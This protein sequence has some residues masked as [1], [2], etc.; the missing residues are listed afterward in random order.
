[1]QTVSLLEFFAL[2]VFSLLSLDMILLSSCVQVLPSNSS[3]PKEGLPPPIE[4]RIEKTK[5]PFRVLLHWINPVLPDHLINCTGCVYHK[6]KIEKGNKTIHWKYR[7]INAHNTYQ[8]LAVKPL[9]SLRLYMCT[10]QTEME[11]SRWSEP[12][13]RIST[14]SESTAVTNLS[15]VCL[16]LEKMTC[17]WQPGPK[18]PRNTTYRLYYW[19]KPSNGAGGG[20]TEYSTQDKTHQTC[21]FPCNT[22]ARYL[23][24]IN[25]S[26]STMKINPKSLIIEIENYVKPAVPVGFNTSINNTELFLQWETPNSNLNLEY[27]LIFYGSTLTWNVTVSNT[28]YY[29]LDY[30]ERGVHKV[31]IQAKQELY[32]IIQGFSSDLRCRDLP[33]DLRKRKDKNLRVYIWLTTCCIVPIILVILLLRFWH[34]LVTLVW[35]DIPDP[36][37]AFLALKPSAKGDMKLGAD[38]SNKVNS[39]DAYSHI[40]VLS[41]K[42]KSLEEKGLSVGSLLIPHTDIRANELLALR[43]D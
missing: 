42:S 1:M 9:Q 29:L 32:Y 34:R 7:T 36:S 40:E 17:H 21:T 33:V 8:K 24:F 11:C 38:K 35:P 5:S 19:M 26:S 3:Q 31:C 18:A 12:V 15:C 16:N 28:F 22:K 13:S 25:G 27:V 43:M 6:L 2:A 30:D 41:D 20:C 4:L 10:F 39:F 37:H 14:F 23:I